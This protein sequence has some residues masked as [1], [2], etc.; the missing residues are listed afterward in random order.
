[1][2]P[3]GK[4]DTC[5]ISLMGRPESRHNRQWVAQEFVIPEM[6]ELEA[7]TSGVRGQEAVEPGNIGF[8]LYWRDECYGR[9]AGFATF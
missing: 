3:P 9:S 2:N 8:S 6:R 1:M 4:A 5:I 7:L